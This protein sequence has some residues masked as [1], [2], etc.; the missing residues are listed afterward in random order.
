MT[1]I[2]R[3]YFLDTPEYTQPPIGSILS[4]HKVYS[5]SRGETY[6]CRR[7]QP[8][9][10]ADRKNPRLRGRL[11]TKGSRSGHLGPIREGR[12]CECAVAEAVYG[13]YG[14]N[15]CPMCALKVARKCLPAPFRRLVASR[16]LSFS[17]YFSQ[18]LEAK[19][20][21]S[22]RTIQT[23]FRGDI[24]LPAALLV[25]VYIRGQLRKST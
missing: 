15:E 17:P 9:N 23:V 6:F 5:G 3:V 11:T 24:L 16:T 1:R 19:S 10:M 4:M 22:A 21:R 25:Q 20:M 13:P 12:A 7:R 8:A 14:A 2:H 18:A